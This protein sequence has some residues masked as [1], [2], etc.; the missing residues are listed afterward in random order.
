MGVPQIIMI[1]LWTL[2]LGID[3]ETHGKPKTGNDNAM[4]TILGIIINATILY[5]G[6]FWT[7]N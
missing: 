5:Y 7:N 2:A 1:C 4:T 6:G 3:L